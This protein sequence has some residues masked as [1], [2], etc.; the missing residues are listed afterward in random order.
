M[1][2]EA[3]DAREL[4]D[5][6]SW[7]RRR[8]QKVERLIVRDSHLHSLGGAKETKPYTQTPLFPS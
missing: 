6:L 8:V 5:V 4:W 1:S 2:G 7:E 3:R